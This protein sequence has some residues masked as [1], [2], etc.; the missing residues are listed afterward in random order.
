MFSG[1]SGLRGHN[2]TPRDAGS[3]ARTTCESCD[4]I[5]NANGLQ[6]SVLYRIYVLRDL[7]YEPR[8][9][10]GVAPLH[11]YFPFSS[12]YRGNSC[13]RGITCRGMDPR[14]H[15]SAIEFANTLH[16]APG[17]VVRPSG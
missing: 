12:C 10:L 2:L 8:P 9:K 13:T 11:P 16:G 17:H 7:D 5:S 14:Y 15:R 3:T 6:L 1:T 4:L